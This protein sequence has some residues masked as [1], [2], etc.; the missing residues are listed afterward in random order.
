MNP[1]MLVACLIAQ[2]PAPAATETKAK[3]NSDLDIRFLPGAR[4]STMKQL[5]DSLTQSWSPAWKDKFTI[6]PADGPRKWIKV[7]SCADIKGIDV[8]EADTRPATDWDFLIVR[9][10]WCQALD[11]IKR[12]K[13]SKRSY[14]AEVLAAKN[15]AEFLPASV[16]DGIGGEAQATGQ[17]NQKASSARPA[18]SWAQSDR[19]LKLAEDQTKDCIRLEGTKYV[20]TVVYYDTGDFNGDGIED[21]LLQVSTRAID[22]SQGEGRYFIMT[23]TKPSGVL[24]VVEKL[25]QP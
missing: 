8:K 18:I 9:A 13:P 10:D 16:V 11:V 20:A 15:P 2:T 25:N 3:S 14:V 5:E 24:T 23:R 6:R 1:A 4:V 21:V 19:G 12:A 17:E 22:A 7:K